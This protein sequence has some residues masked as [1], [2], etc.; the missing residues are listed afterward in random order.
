MSKTESF[1]SKFQKLENL[2]KETTN[3]TDQTHFSDKLRKAAA[4]NSYIRQ[5]YGLIEDMYS[6]RN[7]FSHNDRQ[8]YIAEINEMALN[9]LD[10]IIKSIESPPTV[11]SKFEKDVFETTSEE[12]IFGV[13]NT[14]KERIYTHVPVWENAK[15][16]GVFSYTSFFEWLNDSQSQTDKEIT[17]VKKFFKDINK[18]YLNSPVV[19][20]L[21]IPENK[22]LYEIP[23]V[24]EEYV[25]KAQ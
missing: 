10:E 24:F 18:K 7:V 20:Y 13:M 19:N 17:F 12:S 11:I 2:I 6:L 9:K 14:M 25:K 23:L 16:I 22:N 4:T 8:K 5:N 1:I 3:S 21:L 15:L